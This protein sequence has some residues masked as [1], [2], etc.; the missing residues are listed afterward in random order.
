MPRLPPSS[1]RSALGR[2]ALLAAVTLPGVAFASPRWRIEGL[3]PSAPFAATLER[4][5]EEAHA[6][7]SAW[8]REELDGTV[9]IVW[10]T[11]STPPPEYRVAVSAP[12]AG[13]AVPSRDL[14]LLFAQAIGS[15]P[16]KL[17]PVLLHEMCHLLLAVHT[18]RADL[19]PPRWLDEGLAMWISGTWDLGLDWRSDDTSL[20][21]D[22]A[23]AGSLIPFDD[24]DSSF[25][26]G[27]FFHLAYAQCH[28]FVARLVTEHGGEENVRRLLR[29]LAS[30]DDFPA[31]F[32]ATYGVEFTEVE[33]DWRASIRPS[34]PFG[35][36]PSAATLTVFGGVLAG[37][38]VA[39]RFVQVRRRLAQPEPAPSDSPPADVTPR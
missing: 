16:D 39:V 36:I 12:V 1:V 25:P 33:H 8:F 18:D 17:R 21:A 32:R 26:S 5:A 7:S 38:L 22:A 24:L 13:L 35:R 10:V 27:P 15:R 19:A 29:R 20:L 30:D 3:P 34:G 31:A 28:S 6:A 23:A 4:E 9:T 14:I 2:G 11:G 37:L